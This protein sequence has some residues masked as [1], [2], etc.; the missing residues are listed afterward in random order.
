MYPLQPNNN[1]LPASC[2]AVPRQAVA[3]MLGSH[4]SV[5][6]MTNTVAYTWIP[7]REGIWERVPTRLT[8]RTFNVR[9]RVTF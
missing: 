4:F 3:S 2:T 6:N 8:P 9:M 5:L 7:N 1:E